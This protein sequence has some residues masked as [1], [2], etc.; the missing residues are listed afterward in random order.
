M[1]TLPKSKMA[2]TEKRH[3]KYHYKCSKTGD[4]E[5]QKNFV[6]V[7]HKPCRN[8]T[9]CPLAAD[10]SHQQY[11]THHSLKDLS[12]SLREASHRPRQVR[13]PDSVVTVETKFTV[14][15]ASSDASE[16]YF[17]WDPHNPG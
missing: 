9:S 11:F 6:C 3:C 12:A 16:L 8:G 7:Y 15:V 4:P 14:E 5:H 2:A 1:T 13:R 17:E 10:P